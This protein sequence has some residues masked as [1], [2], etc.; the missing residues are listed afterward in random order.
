MRD[1]GIINLYRLY[2]AELDQ[3]EMNAL[4]GGCSCPCPCAC[5]FDDV[6]NSS[7]SKQSSQRYA[8]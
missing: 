4:K 7:N 5:G 2:K 6:A 1:I 8:Y 3:R